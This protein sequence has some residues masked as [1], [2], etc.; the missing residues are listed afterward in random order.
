VPFFG[1]PHPARASGALPR[2]LPG[3]GAVMA[4]PGEQPCMGV[5]T[6]FYPASCLHRVRLSSRVP[7]HTV[8]RG[9]IAIRGRADGEGEL[10]P[11]P[12][13]LPGKVHLL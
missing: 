9:D 13:S 2:P 7:P 4:I 5:L 6:S 12:L 1:N 3:A 10:V 8:D 11:P